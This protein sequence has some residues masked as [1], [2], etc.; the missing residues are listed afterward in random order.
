MIKDMDNRESSYI[1]KYTS[2][3]KSADQYT[4]AHSV[5]VA[6]YAMLMAKWLGLS[7]KEVSFAV[8]AGLL[9]DLGK[10]KIPSSILQKKGPLTAEEFTVMKS[11]PLQSYKLVYNCSNM[12]TEIKEAALLHH[13]RLDGSGY[14]LG[15]TSMSILARIVA[16]AD[17]YDA[18]TSDRVYKKGATPFK[19]F[20]Y[21]NNEGANLFD[22]HVLNVFITNISALLVGSTVRLTNGDIA[23]IVFIP[24]DRPSNPVLRLN[25]EFVTLPLAS[26][27]IEI[28]QVIIA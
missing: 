18:M 1:V 7:K 17:V 19:V 12:D 20:E 14:P 6:F 15:I 26:S 11:H 13:E 27:E 5:N 2:Q 22:L 16:I 25:D 23:K 28:E 10:T 4:Y 3:L 8:Q 21:F 24:Q 9:H